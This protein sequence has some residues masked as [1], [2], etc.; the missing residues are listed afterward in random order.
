M[1]NIYCDKC[2]N[3]RQTDDEALASDESSIGWMYHLD[4]SLTEHWEYTSPEPL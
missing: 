3:R 2:D 4:T 1:S